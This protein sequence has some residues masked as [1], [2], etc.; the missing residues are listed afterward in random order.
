MTR[1]LAVALAALAA[2]PLL[3]GCTAADE[4]DGTE[5][6]SQTPSPVAAHF[7]TSPGGGEG[8]NHALLEGE[9]GLV[10]GCLMVLKAVDGETVVPIFLKTMSPR[11]DGQ[12]RTLTV[13]DREYAVG[14][15]VFFGG[16]YVGRASVANHFAVPEQC[17][18]RRAYFLVHDTTDEAE[19]H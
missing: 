17:A 7:V 5:A 11:W 9:L 19:L 10:K 13:D 15:D 4:P 14:A 12:S 1:G 3:V 18:G 2:V 6:A 16:G 8:G